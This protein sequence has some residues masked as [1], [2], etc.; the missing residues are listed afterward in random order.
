VKLNSKE[1]GTK[2]ETNKEEHMNWVHIDPLSLQQL[3]FF[4]F[5]KREMSAV[6]GFFAYTYQHQIAWLSEC[7]LFKHPH[8]LPKIH[9]ADVHA[10]PI[11]KIAY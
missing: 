8:F 7:G 5:L 3:M 11:F 6:C 9:A 1:L 2:L 10:M 4:Q